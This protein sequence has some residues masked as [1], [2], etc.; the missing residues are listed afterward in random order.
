MAL[1]VTS[2][3]SQRAARASIAD[4][5]R[6][7]SG[8]RCRSVRIAA[9]KG[10]RVRA[11]LGQRPR[12]DNVVSDHGVSAAIEDQRAIVGHAAGAER[13]RPT[14]VTD[15]QRGVGVDGRRAAVAV[16]ARERQRT[17][18]KRQRYLATRGAVF[19]H[20]A[21]AS[22]RRHRQRA[23]AAC[24]AVGDRPAATAHVFDRRAE[25]VQVNGCA[26]HNGHAAAEGALI[27]QH[28][29]SAEDDR[30]AAIVASEGQYSVSANLGSVA[31]DNVR[32]NRGRD[33]GIQRNAPS[34][35]QG[36]GGN[37]VI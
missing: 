31:P 10:Q 30:V 18:A 28:D 25:S 14:A 3:A 29:R 13:T 21:V 6:T 17:R 1:S 19:E 33:V 7:E 24:G 27:V 2:P 37:R 12:A 8:N 20:S 15:L 26:G 5:Q 34:N 4:L 23:G 9:R 36:A 32:R 22:A 11:F 16:R 35:R